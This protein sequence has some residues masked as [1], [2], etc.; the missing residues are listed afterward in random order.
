MS[1]KSIQVIQQEI[2]SA[3]QNFDFETNPDWREQ[4][5]KIYELLQAHDSLQKLSNSNWKRTQ[6]QR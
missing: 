3:I 5:F 6:Q 1:E 2:R 4:H